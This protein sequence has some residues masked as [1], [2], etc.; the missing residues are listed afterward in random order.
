MTSTSTPTA[1]EEA[2]LGTM[3]LGISDLDLE[4]GLPLRMLAI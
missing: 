1:P 3:A 2:I 4:M